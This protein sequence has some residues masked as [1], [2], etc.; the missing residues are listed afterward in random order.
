VCFFLLR[1][2][3]MMLTAFARSFQMAA[4]GR[5]EFNP[6]A[7]A[8]V[9]EATSHL[10]EI[11]V[12]ISAPFIGMNFLVT[13]AFS[14]LGRAIPKMNVF[15]MS[16]SLRAITGLGLLASAGALLVRYLVTE[17]S[18]APLRMLQVLPFH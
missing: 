9:V 2:D 12:R 4:A 7:A 6:G 5:V 15:V 18:E 3:Q 16:F 14:V 13:L 11:G 17:F 10:I 8:T 1:G